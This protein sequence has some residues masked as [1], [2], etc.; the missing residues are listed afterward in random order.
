MG[1]AVQNAKREDP[2]DRGVRMHEEATTLRAKG[3]APQAERL[4]RQALRLLESNLG[5]SHPDVANVLN[6]LGWIQY[7][8]AEQAFRRSVQ[9]MRR[10]RGGDDGA[11]IRLQAGGVV[12]RVSR[13]WP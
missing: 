1:L 9:I 11:R 4:C 8:A 6:A 12:F 10:S 2:V 7:E 3:R 5:P 13:T